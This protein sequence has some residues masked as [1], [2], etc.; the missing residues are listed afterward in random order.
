[1]KTMFLLLAVVGLTFGVTN[2][3]AED[4]KI[5]LDKLPKAV[6]DAV[7]AKFPKAEMK[8]A[9]KEKEDGKITYEVTIADGETK[10][11]VDVTEAGVITGFEKAVAL[12]DLPKVITD[13]VA[14]KYPACKAKSGEVVYTIKDGKDVLSYYEVTV[15]VDGK[16]VELEI[17]EDGKLKSEEKK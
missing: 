4:E 7:K 8:S 5:S 11:D 16:D 14:A 12:K 6:V 13:A 10:V 1:M 15:T 3:R 2:L 9:M 17:L